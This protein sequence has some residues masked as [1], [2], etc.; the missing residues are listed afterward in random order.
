MKFLCVCDGGNVRSHALAFILKHEFRQEAIAV[1]RLYFSKESM[2]LLCEWADRIVV[3]Q[4]HMEASI[5]PKFKDKLR[6]V[7]VGV[8]RYGIWVHP[9]LL[10]QVKTGAEWLLNG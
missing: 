7:D 6:C 10:P 5:D 9:E 3:M 1:G 2:V 8:D 4:P